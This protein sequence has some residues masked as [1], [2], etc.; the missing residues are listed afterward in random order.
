M[1]FDQAMKDIKTLYQAAKSGG[2]NDI[3]AYIEAVNDLAKNDRSNYFLMVEYIISSSVGLETLV[4]FI[5]SGGLPI[6]G[7]EPLVEQI[8]NCI[9][10]CEV[11]RA[12]KTPYTEALAYLKTFRERYEHCF[13]MFE[14]SFDSFMEK[15]LQKKKDHKMVPEDADLADESTRKKIKDECIKEYVSTYYGTN[16]G[17]IQNRRLAVGMISRFGECAIPDALITAESLGED[18]VNT[19]LSYINGHY[20]DQSPGFHQRFSEAAADLK[21][22]D[23][24]TAAYQ[25]SVNRSCKSIISKLEARRTQLFQEAAIM[26]VDP[27]EM[28]YSESEKQAIQDLIYLK[29]YELTCMEDASQ[30]KA[31]QKEIYQLYETYAD[32]LDE[33]CADSVLG[34]LPGARAGTPMTEAPWMINTR[35]K[36]TGEMPGYIRRNHDLGYGEDEKPKKVRPDDDSDPTLDDFRRPSATPKDE[37]ES[38]PEE[39]P[40][41]DKDSGSGDGSAQTPV[42]NYYYYTYNNSHN[43]NTNSFNRDSSTHDDHSVTKKTDDH[44]TGKRINSDD[45]IGSGEEKEDS[46]LQEGSDPFDLDI[47]HDGEAIMESRDLDWKKEVHAFQKLFHLDLNKLGDV[48]SP[49][50]QITLTIGGKKMKFTSARGYSLSTGRRV[51]HYTSVPTSIHQFNVN[52]D[53]ITN[54]EIG[55][56]DALLHYF[57]LNDPKFEKMSVAQCIKQYDLKADRIIFKPCGEIGLLFNSNLDSVHGIGLN[58]RQDLRVDDGGESIALESVITEAVGD[59]DDNKPQSDHPIKDVLTDIDRGT[60]K[61]QQ[62]AKKKVQDV[63][64][65]GRAAMKPVNRTKQWVTKMVYDWKDADENNIKERLADP[66]ARK[67]VFSAISWAIKTGAFAK[68][69]LLFNPV[70]LFLTVTK[71]FGK[72]KKIQRLRNEMLAEIKMELE[73]IEEKIRDADRNRDQAEKYKLMRFKTELN[74]KYLR[75]AD[76][77]KFRKII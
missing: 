63:Q 61:F 62:S 3:S 23:V 11:A 45:N 15:R 66:H 24:A 60:V 40:V 72:N 22:P 16:D 76:T 1:G 13:K 31:A 4:P 69:G 29:E 70:F 57:K 34:M 7:Y 21:I 5:E 73:I 71:N 28:Q 32:I 64:N 47:F 6:A 9:R 48:R 10:K 65:V 74:K 2:S 46:P 26:G 8:E 35:N 54:D 38:E 20:I 14:S 44:S 55:I 42:A 68:A 18:A 43:K 36:K 58:I 39:E 37:P 52:K 51:E 56:G 12:D 19:M 67:N 25:E 30:I 59:A 17:G 27:A 50:K 75:V 49:E 41:S 33:Q 53:R 77:T